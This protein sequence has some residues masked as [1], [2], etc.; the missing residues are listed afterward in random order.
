MEALL[1][2]RIVDS[3]LWLAVAI[4]MVPSVIRYVRGSFDNCDEVRSILFGAAI[5]FFS[6]YLGR[7]FHDE[8]EQN[9]LVAINAFSGLLAILALVVCYQGRE[10]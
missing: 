1:L 4:F 9:L 5:I 7:I 8:G 3:L 2:S 6:T 10:R